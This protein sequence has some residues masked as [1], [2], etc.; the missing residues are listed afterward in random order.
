MPSLLISLV[1]L[2]IVFVLD[3]SLRNETVTK[4]PSNREKFCNFEVVLEF[5][6]GCTKGSLQVFPRG[7]VQL[8]DSRT[9]AE[10]KSQNTLPGTTDPNTDRVLKWTGPANNNTLLQF[11]QLPLREDIRNENERQIT[12]AARTRILVTQP[13]PTEES[14][15]QIDSLDVAVVNPATC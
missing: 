12:F 14:F 1:V 2:N 6:R 11:W 9:T 13:G 4:L 7:Y 10:F 8:E 3:K 5:P 15:L